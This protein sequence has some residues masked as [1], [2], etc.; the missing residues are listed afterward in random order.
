MVYDGHLWLNAA[1][2]DIMKQPWRWN[3]VPTIV[4]YC[5]LMTMYCL[6]IMLVPKVSLGKWFHLPEAFSWLTSAK[7]LTSPNPASLHQM[8]IWSFQLLCC[9]NS[10]F[11]RDAELYN[12]HLLT[13]NW[14]QF[15][16]VVKTTARKLQTGYQDNSGQWITVSA[17]EITR[18]ML[19]PAK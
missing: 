16:H 14:L 3:N 15:F 12:N 13:S 17:A 18:G 4:I 9:S 11:L 19:L 7:S 1:L 5:D 10:T 8:V 2:Q 6:S